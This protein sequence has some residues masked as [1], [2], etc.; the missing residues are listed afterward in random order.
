MT[1]GALLAVI[2]IASMFQQGRDWLQDNWQP[3]AI[4]IFVSALVVGSINAV[5]Q[6]RRRLCDVEA[7][8]KAP[9]V[10]G[11]IEYAIFGEKTNGKLFGWLYFAL[12]KTGAELVLSSL[13]VDMSVVANGKAGGFGLNHQTFTG[14][15]ASD[16]FP[17]DFGELSLFWPHYLSRVMESGEGSREGWILVDTDAYPFDVTEG[18]L[19]SALV[20]ATLRVRVDTNTLP[21]KGWVTECTLLRQ[22]QLNIADADRVQHVKGLAIFELSPSLSRPYK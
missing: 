16:R 4:L 8:N 12:E 5:I 6:E 21:P 9:S 17:A 2:A 3:V 14:Q 19:I 20:G 10:A 15:Q 11:T 18:G 7:A 1:G 22:E 13:E